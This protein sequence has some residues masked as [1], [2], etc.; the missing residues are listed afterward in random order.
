MPM[1]CPRCSTPPPFDPFLCTTCG[2]QLLTYLDEPL[3]PG[4]GVRPEWTADGVGTR[5]DG[6]PVRAGYP[7][8]QPAPPRQPDNTGPFI[9]KLLFGLF[10]TMILA[11]AETVAVLFFFGA[12]AFALWRWPRARLLIFIPAT[13]GIAAVAWFSADLIEELIDE[14]D[15]PAFIAT[16]TPTPDRAATSTAIAVAGTPT[17]APA[18]RTATATVVAGENRVK[19]SRARARWLR[20][21]NATALAELDDAL[22]LIPGLGETLNLRALVRIAAGDHE[23]AAADAERAVRNQPAN[24]AY[25]DTRG[26]A[27]LK[28][29]RYDAAVNEYD[30]VLASQRPDSYVAAYLGRGVAR[31]ALGRL[32]EARTDLER[33]LRLLPD[34]E[35]DPQL[36][37]LETLARRALDPLAPR[38]GSPSPA[39]SPVAL[40]TPTP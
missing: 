7:P 2:E 20:G 21:D 34:T 27:L 35:P 18:A 36:A 8:Y 6:G 12:L 30:T 16:P 39:A 29:G 15:T 40:G 5:A 26:Y 38:P 3:G 17:L 24:L 11:A 10:L 31:T 25:H 1:R 9:I 33:G 22:T 14:M 4:T 28:L 13:I 23:G 32:A 19:L 37:D